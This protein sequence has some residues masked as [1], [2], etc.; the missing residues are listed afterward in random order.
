MPFYFWYS[1][2][3]LV[4]QSETACICVTWQ[5]D[6]KPSLRSHFHDRIENFY[7]MISNHSHLWLRS[8]L[9]HWYVSSPNHLVWDIEAQSRRH[10]IFGTF[11]YIWFLKFPSIQFFQN[12]FLFLSQK[13]Y[14]FNEY[15]WKSRYFFS[16][17]MWN[18]AGRT[19]VHYTQ[20]I[21]IRNR[22][23]NFSNKSSIRVINYCYCNIRGSG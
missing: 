8:G 3:T 14:N 20:T 22:S 23:G 7:R 5:P 11:W 18:H 1:L 12:D 4:D 2:K 13:E 21:Q 17:I 19:T 15:V 16:P 6:L 9:V 10:F